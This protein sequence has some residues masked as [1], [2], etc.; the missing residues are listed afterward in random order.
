MIKPLK[1]VKPGEPRSVS[2]KKIE[3]GDK[4][5]GSD[6]Y[7]ILVADTLESLQKDMAKLSKEGWLPAVGSIGFRYTGKPPGPN[8][9]RLFIVMTRLLG[10]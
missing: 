10:R 4:M 2:L 6:T 3:P 8:K 9:L 5:D 1:K 7:R